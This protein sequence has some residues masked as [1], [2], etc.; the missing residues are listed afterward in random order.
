M[1]YHVGQIGHAGVTV[2]IGP[3][4]ARGVQDTDLGYAKYVIGTPPDQAR[5][6][7]DRWTPLEELIADNEGDLFR[8]FMDALMRELDSRL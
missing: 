8:V 2:E 5:I 1:D 4:M 3:T 6:H 7:Q